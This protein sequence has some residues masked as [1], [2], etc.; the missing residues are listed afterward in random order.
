MKQFYQFLAFTCLL[1]SLGLSA[2]AVTTRSALAP[3]RVGGTQ[4]TEPFAFIEN[5]GQI[6]DT[7]GRQR[8]DIAFVAASGGMRVFVTPNRI[9][10]VFA[11]YEETTD[12]TTPRRRTT[13][14]GTLSTIRVDMDLV[15]ARADAAIRAEEALDGTI[16]VYAPG[17]ADGILGLRMYK[18]LVFENVYENIDLVYHTAEGT[19]KYDFVVR[20]GGRVSDIR[21]RYTGAEA[22]RAAEDGGL[23]VVT[24]LG[25]MLEGAPISYQTVP[26]PLSQDARMNV[27]SSFHI[28]NNDVTFSV[29]ATDPTATLVIDPTLQWATYYGGANFEFGHAVTSDVLG[30]VI[31]TG[32]TFSTNFPVSAGTLQSTNAGSQDAFIVKFDAAGVRQWATYYGGIVNDPAHG[33][34]VDGTGNIYVGGYTESVNFPVTLGAHQ[35]TKANAGDGW[36]L[37]LTPAGTRLWATYVGASNDDVI[38]AVTSDLAGNIAVVGTTASP[39]LITTPGVVQPT[40]GGYTD[41]FVMRFTPAGSLVWSTFHGGA[42]EESG[43]DISYDAAG[44]VVF[45]GTT[46]SYNFPLTPNPSQSALAGSND[47][48][49]VKL[50]SAGAAMWSTYFGGSSY[51]AA[52]AVAVDAAGA[53]TI[54]GLTHSADLPT[55]INA[56]RP[57]PAGNEDA[58]VVHYSATGTR[59]WAT[60][61]GGALNDEAFAAGADALGRITIGGQ[62]YSPNFPITAGALQSTRQGLSDAFV[63]KFDSSGRQVWG[64]YFGGN[65]DDAVYGLSSQYSGNVLLAG[66]TFSTDFPATPGAFQSTKAGSFDAI[67][68]KICDVKPL[69]TMSR[70]INMCPGD[71]VTLDAGPGY[72]SYLWSTSETTQSI[73]VGAGGPYWVTVTDGIGC[74]GTS[75]TMLVNISPVMTADAGPDLDICHGSSTPIGAPTTGGTLPLRYDWTPGL[76]LSDSTIAQPDASPLNTTLYTVTVTDA[77]G[78]IS[79]DDV[80]VRVFPNPFVDA[81]AN[82]TICY[83]SSIMLGDSATLG[84]PPYAYQW[85]P[86]YALDD[87]TLALPTATPLVTTRYFVT[88]TD[89]KGCTFTDSVLVTVNRITANAGPDRSICQGDSIVIGTAASGGIAPLSY[90]WVPSTGLSSTSIAAPLASPGATQQYIVTV[91]DQRGCQSVD[92]VV[93]HVY[94]A[95]KALAGDDVEICLG[96]WTVIGDTAVCGT[97][98]YQYAWTPST[99]LSD[100]SIAHPI[101]NPLVTTTYTLTVTDANSLSVTDVVTVTVNNPPIADAGQDS[102][103]ICGRTSTVIGQP[104]T[105]GAPPYTYQW[106]P[107]IGLDDPTGA[108]TLAAPSVSTRYFVQVTDSKGCTSV[109]SMFVEVSSLAVDA[110]ADTYIC[111]GDSLTI[112]NDATGGSGPYTYS[113]LPTTGLGTPAAAVTFAKPASTTTYVVTVTDSLGCTASDTITIVVEPLP[114]AFAGNDTTVC[115]VERLFLGG[116]A[117]GGTGPYRYS[118]SPAVDLSSTTIMQPIATPRQTRTYVLTVTDA[119][120]CKGYDTVTVFVRPWPII[121]AG[122]DTLICRADSI[123]LG[124]PASGGMPPYAYHWTPSYGLNDSTAMNPMASPF[125]STT[126]VLTVTDALGCISK[127][128]LR[129]SVTTPALAKIEVLGPTIL[130][131]GDSVWLDADPTLMYRGYLW[132]T[133]DTTRRIKVGATGDYQ[134]QVNMNT[135]CPGIT[136]QVRIWVATAPEPLVSLSGPLSFCEGGFVTLSVDSI[137]FASIRWSTGARTASI[138][139]RAS[140]TYYVDVTNFVGCP[141]RSLP[142]TVTVRPLPT[143]TV[144][145]SGP[146]VLCEGERV[147]LSVDDAYASYLWSN[148][149]TTRSITVTQGGSY[150]VTVT[151]GFN[152]SN[153]SAPTVVTF[154]PNPTPVI[155][156]TGSLSFCEGGSVRLDAGAGF[157]AYLWS[158]GATTRSITVASAGSYTCTVTTNAGCSGTTPPRTVVVHPRPT[159]VIVPLGSETFCVG[160]SVTLDAGGGYQ[161]YLWS[162]GQRTRM[163]T[164]KTAGVYT[165]TVTDTLGCGATAAGRTI[166]VNPRPVVSIT[167]GGPLTFCAGDSVVLDAGDHISYVWSNG[168]RTRRITVRESGTYSVRVE[169]VLGCSQTSADVTVTRVAPPEPVITAGGPLSFCQGGSVVLDAGAGY[170][171]YEWS[172]GARTR[173]LTVTQA[174]TYNVRVTNSTGCRGESPF[175]N[176]TVYPLPSPPIIAQVGLSSL[177]STPATTYQWHLAGAPISGATSRVYT[178]TRSGVYTVTITDANGCSATSAQFAFTLV[179]IDDESVITRYDLYPDPNV[180]QAVLQMTLATP[181]RVRLTLMNLLGQ[182]LLV[183]DEG[184]VST[185]RRELDLRSFTPGM[186]FLHI[187]AGDRTMIRKLI[188]Q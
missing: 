90:T 80:L 25:E 70:S 7:E 52:R 138:T 26:D 105:G 114:I 142:Y 36:L 2:H 135:P 44:N 178:P 132:N 165:V 176:V 164:I 124:S 18:R 148:G 98:P 170:A 92:T 87:D 123:M 140:G 23:R 99:G 47:A 177:A 179:G 49:A 53:V 186:Y 162:S 187:H 96:G 167:A 182:Q 126:Y 168:Q 40:F 45:T 63:V 100:T 75:D 127:D 19:L 125:Q 57:F 175:V 181:M 11:R 112:G 91:V 137:R 61:L 73:K 66:W 24:P 151:D 39:D 4:A 94:N 102:I 50:T 128:T 12:A 88:V 64:T 56:L 32:Y 79:S 107:V 71:S 30:N 35:T 10:Y 97:A 108:Q 55:S 6:Y 82:D 185:V 152:C 34:A 8:T 160:D 120:G 21:L 150:S 171:T 103:F 14:E 46:L 121:N 157:A 172:T 69:V 144:S 58:F 95:L 109:D 143:P 134:V 3:D 188:R 104:A 113:W 110:G 76:G 131:P 74:T 180:G 154:N 33:I 16:N 159:P 43:E 141:A 22:V 81:G 149:A 166:I 145:A 38:Y 174:G 65:S 101:A 136:P 163:I 169:N 115:R 119:K 67:V 51:D 133:G 9:S 155:A 54:T 29:A 31:A 59:L 28:E 184:I 20:P 146:V 72:A 41:A 77:N 122:S 130:C 183:H 42:N 17:A 153:A 84:T 129:I 15:G 89:A 37:K 158:N 161:A 147:V 173:R 117:T 83:G 1:M 116:P 60:Y 156:V 5:R 27:R 48:Y 106:S 68:V 139:V 86:N 62:T 78:C 111:A 13:N 93:V 118:W 85:T